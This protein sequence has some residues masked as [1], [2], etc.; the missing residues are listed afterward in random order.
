[1]R[2]KDFLM[3]ESEESS[4]N[5]DGADWYY[6]RSLSPSDANSTKNALK[7]PQDFLFLQA[8]WKREKDE[9]GRDF[10]NIDT[11]DFFSK[12][13]TDVQSNTMPKSGFWK[14][15]SDK[16]PNLSIKKNV[17]LNVISY[18]KSSSDV[19]DLIHLNPISIDKTEE[20]NRIFGEFKPSYSEIPL[21]FDKPWS[22]YSGEVKMRRKKK[23]KY[24]KLLNNL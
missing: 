2:F 21:N 13:Y 8:R 16:K 17:D 10:I 4:S 24:S 9:W 15:S 12:K 22:P 3:L 23:R 1:M 5:S 14:N 6:G 11:K 20:L 19:K 18:N 7:N